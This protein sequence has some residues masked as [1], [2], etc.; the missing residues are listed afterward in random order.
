M[1]ITT[2]I[3]NEMTGVMMKLKIQTI[4]TKLIKTTTMNKVN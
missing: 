1:M 4:K 3:S 2:W